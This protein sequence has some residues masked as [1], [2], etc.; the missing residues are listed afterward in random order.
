LARKRQPFQQKLRT[1]EHVIA[2]LADNHVERQGLLCG[3]SL[4]RI[5]HDYGIDLILF[6]YKGSGELEDG[7]ILLQVK[8]T[9]R[10][11]RVH[12]GQAI[13]FR[14]SRS[15]VQG[16]LRKVMPVILIVYDVSA[17][18]AYWLYLQRYFEC[19]SG[20]NLFQAGQTITV[21]L[22]MSQILT[23]IA[24]QQFA[25]FRDHVLGQMGGGIQHHV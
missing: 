10:T 2:D 21:H 7:E 13:P 23:P 24:V 14:V 4:E 25:S 19:L 5:V 6:T 16:W 18:V 1:R 8:A 9:E 22:P 15:D 3:C 12:G 17:D 20:F 11:R